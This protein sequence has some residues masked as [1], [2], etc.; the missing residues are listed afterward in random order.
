VA[1]GEVGVELEPGTQDQQ[2]ALERGQGEDRLESIGST[3]SGSKIGRS[4][5]NA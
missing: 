5:S 1:L 4:R 3:S 2:R